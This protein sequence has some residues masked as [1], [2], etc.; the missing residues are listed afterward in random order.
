MSNLVQ[1]INNEAVT[2]TL[3]IAEGVGNQHKNIISMVRQY[4]ADLEEFGRVAFETRP[5]ETL[6]G[7]Q[8]REVALL[9]ER[10]ATLLLSYMRNTDII[11]D[12]KKRLVKTFYQMA[13]AL[14]DQTFAVPQG[15]YPVQDHPTVVNHW[16][17]LAYV[18]H[19]TMMLFMN[20]FHGQGANHDQAVA[21]VMGALRQSQEYM[22]GLSGAQR[23]AEELKLELLKE[24]PLW[25]NIQ[26]CKQM[27]LNNVNTAKLCDCHVS[28]IRKHMR[29]MEELGILTPPPNMAELQ[30]MASRLR[31]EVH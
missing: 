17:G 10:Q 29:K 5:F 15:N 13:Q 18:N 16:A 26:S 1:I 30:A 22:K 20:F 24:R 9:N 6:G 11:R 23:Q 28:T 21:L 3:G 2:D 14:R 31:L 12:F 4:L 19:A 8:K 25:R 27:G 7:S